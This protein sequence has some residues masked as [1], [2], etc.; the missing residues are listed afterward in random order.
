MDTGA[1]RAPEPRFGV[2]RMIALYKIVK[3][4]LLL[5]VAYG[6]LRLRD[7]SLVAKLL[8]WASS[9][10]YGVEHHYGLEHRVVSQLVEWF[11]GLS[12]S[13]A[14]AL[15]LVTLGYA[16]VFAVEGVG[17]WMQ[18]RWAEWLTVVITASLVPLEIWEMF[19]RPTWGK[20]AILLGNIAIVIYLV[21]HVRTHAKA[22]PTELV[23]ELNK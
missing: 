20:L 12:S 22:P 6:E 18:K 10:P 3:V 9:Q 11:S 21:W 19:S 13:R 23:P 4:L 5:L 16:A 2:L 8:A 15:R 1:S 14:E 7:A 17:L